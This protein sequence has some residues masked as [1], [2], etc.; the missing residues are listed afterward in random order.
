LILDP[1]AAYPSTIEPRLYRHHL[2]RLKDSNTSRRKDGFF[3][4][5]EPNSVTSSMN[6]LMFKSFA[7]KDSANNLIDMGPSHAVTNSADTSVLCL[8]H[9]VVQMSILI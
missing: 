6:V 8:S 2:I 5:I 9:N 1:D 4:N 3:V 7:A